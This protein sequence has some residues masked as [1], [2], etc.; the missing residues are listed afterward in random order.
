MSRGARNLQTH[1][2]NLQLSGVH[3]TRL[4]STELA[5]NLVMLMKASKLL[6]A[7]K[8]EPETDN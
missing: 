1:A 3:L 4:D 2:I 7:I 8:K 5:G 6:A